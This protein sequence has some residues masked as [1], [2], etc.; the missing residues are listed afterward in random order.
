GNLTSAAMLVSSNVGRAAGPSTDDLG[1]SPH[2]KTFTN[3]I[4]MKLTLIPA[5]DFFMGSSESVEQILKA[6]PGEYPGEGFQSEHPRRRVTISKP[7]YM[8]TCEVT[9]GEFRKFIE[10]AGYRTDAELGKVANSPTEAASQADNHIWS[11]PAD[12]NFTDLH[13]V[14]HISWNDAVAFCDWLSKTEAKT[15]RLPTQAEWEYACRAGTTTRY[16]SGDDPETLADV[17]NVPNRYYLARHGEQ[18]RFRF[19]YFTGNPQ[20]KRK[21]WQGVDCEPGGSFEFGTVPSVSGGKPVWGGRTVSPGSSVQKQGTVRIT[22]AARDSRSVL[23]LRLDGTRI[24]VPGGTT[25]TITPLPSKWWVDKEDGFDGLAPVASFRPNPFGL[26]DMHGN[27]WEWCGDGYDAHAYEKQSR[28]DP[29][30]PADASEYAIR[31]GCFL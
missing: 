1:R 21:G 25:K 27:V 8:G 13:P 11:S 17:A 3:S 31:G 18:H 24:E 14:A 26:Y 29:V 12:A 6:F 7:F 2:G 4:G 9:I 23:Y 30:G 22:N 20:G 28:I 16:W 15:Y 10:A 19:E 5:G